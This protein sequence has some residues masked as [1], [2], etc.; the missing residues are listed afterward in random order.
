[1]GRFDTRDDAA[2]FG[3]WRDWKGAVTKFTPVQSKLHNR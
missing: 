3:G 1:M 2:L